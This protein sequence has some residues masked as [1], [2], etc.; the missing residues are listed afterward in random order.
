MSVN[1][2]VG[3]GIRMAAWILCGVV[4]S[5]PVFAQSAPPALTLADAVKEALAKNERIVNQADSIAQADLGLRLADI[6]EMALQ[7]EPVTVSGE[8]EDTLREH[9]ATDEE[10]AFLLG[11]SDQSSLFRASKRW[12]GTSPGQRRGQATLKPGS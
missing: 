12:F 11:F 4:L 3:I 8:R 1:R 10:I 2:N 6:E 7:S 5:V 9:G